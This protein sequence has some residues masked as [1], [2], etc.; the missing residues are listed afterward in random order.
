MLAA[1]ILKLPAIE[2]LAWEVD[3]Y[4]ILPLSL[5]DPFAAALPIAEIILGSLLLLGVFTRITGL[6]AGLLT[7][8]FTIAKLKAQFQGLDIDICPCLGPLV[9]LFLGQSLAIDA[10][11]LIS[12][13]ILAAGRSEFLALSAAFVRRRSGDGT[14]NF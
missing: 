4:Q 9:P 7:L 8:S 11:M 2:T 13:F 14:E 10:V 3:Q 12:A 6:I 5:V 1:G